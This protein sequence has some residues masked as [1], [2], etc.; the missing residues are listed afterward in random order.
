MLL[1]TLRVTRLLRLSKIIRLLR[2]STVMQQLEAKYA[3]NYSMLQLYTFLI[4][5]FYL[6]HF[7]ACGWCAHVARSPLLRVDSRFPL[8]LHLVGS[9]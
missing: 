7:I 3:I 5:L 9:H 2:M 6:S 4:A 8:I 1:Q